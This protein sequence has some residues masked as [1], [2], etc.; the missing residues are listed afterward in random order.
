MLCSVLTFC[1]SCLL[2]DKM[3]FLRDSTEL[4]QEKCINTPYLAA[5]EFKARKFVFG[6]LQDPGNTIS[7][8]FSAPKQLPTAE[9]AIIHKNT[10]TG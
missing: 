7:G 10:I 5:K 6:K 9:N 1:Y 8:I 4:S 3:Q 2:S